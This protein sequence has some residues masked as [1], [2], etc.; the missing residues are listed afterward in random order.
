MAAHQ[1]QRLVQARDWYLERIKNE[2]QS[3]T[4][5]RTAQYALERFINTVHGNPYLH[6]IT[7]EMMSEYC[8]GK[9]GIRVGIQAISFNRYRSVLKSFFDRETDMRW[10]DV[11]PVT[12][13]VPRARPDMP[14]KRLMLNGGELMAL[15]EEYCNTPME[16][17]ACSL[18]MNTGLRSNDVRT[19]KVFDVSLASG[20]IQTEIR[21]TK[22]LDVKPITAELHVELVRWLDFYAGKMGVGNRGNLPDDW[23]LLPSYHYSPIPNASE[24]CVRFRPYEVHDHPW[25]LVQRPLGRMGYPTKGEGFH[26]LRRSSARA[27]FELLRESGEA[28]DHALMIVKDFLNHAS[29]AQTEHYLGLDIE[30]TMRDQLLK[31]KSFLPRLRAV[32]QARVEPAAAVISEMRSVI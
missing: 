14:K 2:G 17:V 12:Q 24:P 8:F 4:S 27:F 30:R 20:E 10:V 5:I 23:L 32:E 11:N 29:V 6:N 9:N 7:P 31:D 1:N 16:R 3:Q 15:V 18:G 25:R 19:L 26:T 13:A 22:K 28:R 21:K